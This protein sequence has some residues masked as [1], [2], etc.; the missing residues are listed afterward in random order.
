MK[1]LL[2]AMMCVLSITACDGTGETMSSTIKIALHEDTEH[3]LAAN[4]P[5]IESDCLDAVGSCDYN[6]DARARSGESAALV[7]A[8]SINVGLDNIKRLSTTKDRLTQGRIQNVEVVLRGLPD[9]ST[10]DEN[11]KFIYTLLQKLSAQGWNHYYLPSDPRIDGDQAAKIQSATEVFGQVVS[12]HPWFDP[13]YQMTREQWNV[14][15]DFYNWYF[16][17]DGYYLKVSA[18][19]HNDDSAPATRGTYLVTLEFLTASYFWQPYFP[20]L[21]ITQW[22]DQLPRVLANLKEAR[23]KLEAKARANGIKIDETY[24][25]PPIKA[26]GQ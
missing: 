14:V 11:K 22:N 26:L 4:T 15:S 13:N 10:H 24:Q 6:Y 12:S 17:H 23:E 20:G 9:N 16:Y 1:N 25:D 19:R 2:L 8:G 3:F 7:T 5:N 21:D 18:W